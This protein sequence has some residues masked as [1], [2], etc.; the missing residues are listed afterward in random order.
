MKG[1]IEEKSGKKKAL[2]SIHEASDDEDT[3]IRVYVPWLY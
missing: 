3:G 1:K 2:N